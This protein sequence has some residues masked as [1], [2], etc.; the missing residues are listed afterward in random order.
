MAIWI[1]FSDVEDVIASYKEGKITADNC[2]NQLWF[3]TLNQPNETYMQAKRK[4][5]LEAA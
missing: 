3:L 1:E 2:E 5:G 4:A